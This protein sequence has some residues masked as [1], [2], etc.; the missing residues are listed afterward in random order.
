MGKEGGRHNQ[1]NTRSRAAP[2]RGRGVLS[3][4][5]NSVLTA[6]RPAFLLKYIFLTSILADDWSVKYLP[7]GA[8]SFIEGW[9]LTLIL[10]P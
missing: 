7:D 8:G 9:C 6:I 2:G 10:Q 1:Q 4:P 3:I 5:D